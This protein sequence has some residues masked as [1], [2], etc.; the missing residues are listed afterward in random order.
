MSWLSYFNPFY[1]WSSSSQSVIPPPPPMALETFQLQK[2]LF[3]ELKQVTGSDAISI[4]SLNTES[5][6]SNESLCDMS[7]GIGF[8]ITANDLSNVTLKPVDLEKIK[9]EKKQREL[10]SQIK[11]CHQKLRKTETRVNTY[12]QK[13]KTVY[14]DFDGL[15]SLSVTRDIYENKFNSFVNELLNES[16]YY[17]VV[18]KR[19]KELGYR[20]LIN[21]YNGN[22]V[23]V[24]TAKHDTVYLDVA[25]PKLTGQNPAELFNYLFGSQLK[26]QCIVQKV[27]FHKLGY[28]YHVN[29]LKN[30]LMKD[31]ESDSESENGLDNSLDNGSDNED[32]MSSSNIDF[33]I[34]KKSHIKILENNLKCSSLSEAREIC[35]SYDL[36]P[37]VN[38]YNKIP[39]SYFPKNTKKN[40]ILLCVCGPKMTEIDK[41]YKQINNHADGLYVTEISIKNC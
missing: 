9:L 6:K 23:D 21:K 37:I 22:L 11:N 2:A 16:K 1:W 5:T 33:D 4:A 38:I 29:R 27:V 39:V 19:L 7:S 18:E 25:G 12:A 20:V 3:N 14:T 35:K 32:E 13:G 28:D 17:I 36:S 24:W 30:Q 15:E 40:L 41:I 10:L 8:G 26:E 31:S 34:T